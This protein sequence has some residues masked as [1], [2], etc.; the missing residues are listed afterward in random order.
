MS[1]KKLRPFPSLWT[2]CPKCQEIVYIKE[3]EKTNKCPNESCGHVYL[4]PFAKMLKVR[5]LLQ[6]GTTWGE[7]GRF[8][9]EILDTIDDR[10]QKIAF[11]SKTHGLMI[12]WFEWSQMI[13]KG[14]L[15]PGVPL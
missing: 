14:K 12:E 8:V 4:Y 11:L 9:L 6:Y 7:L 3:I 5:E 2:K 10:N 13:K 1:I 15:S